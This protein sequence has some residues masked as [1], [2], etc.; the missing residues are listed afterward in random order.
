MGE[1][2]SAMTHARQVLSAP[3]NATANL[4]V[5]LVALERRSYAEA[6]DALVNANK[7]DPDSPKVLPLSLVF[8]RLGDDPS[9]RRYLDPYQ[10]KLRAKS[11]SARCEP[12]E[13]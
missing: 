8:A 9:A 2:D 3:S 10:E 5:G 4:V 12:V 1:L 6:R 7:A 13:R 11:E